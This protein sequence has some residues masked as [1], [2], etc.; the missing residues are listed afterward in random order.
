M[1]FITV[2]PYTKTLSYLYYKDMKIKA[3]IGK[4]GFVEAFKK[5][6]GDNKTPLGEFPIRHILY[7]QDRLSLFTDINHNPLKPE[8]GWCDDPEDE[9]YNKQVVIPYKA[10]AENLFRDDNIYD[11]IVILGFNDDPVVKYKGSA[12][13]FHIARDGYL[14]TRGCVAVSKSDMIDLLK[15]CNKNTVFKIVK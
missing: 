11:V 3:C 14:P 5:T 9:N 7:R 8:D 13:F 10:R 15:K 4:E 12:I 6:E 2:K 1:N